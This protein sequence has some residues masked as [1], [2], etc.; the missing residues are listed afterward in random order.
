MGFILKG[1]GF[2]VDG[3]MFAIVHVDGWDA[4]LLH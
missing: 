2:F 1:L 4:A 3:C